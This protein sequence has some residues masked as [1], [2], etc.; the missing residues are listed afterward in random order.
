V[1]QKHD[2]APSVE[3]ET[4]KG[5]SQMKRFVMAAAVVVALVLV[6]S[7]LGAG[8]VPEI[9][10]LSPSFV[11]SS[12]TCENL[13][14]GTTVTAPPGSG[15]GVSV[16]TTLTDRNGVT[17][18][19]NTTH[20]FGSAT[21]Q[22]GNAYVYVYANSFRVSNTTDNL[23]VFSGQMTD[24]FSLSGPGPARL[25]N[26]FTATFTTDFASLVAFSPLESHGDPIDFATG[27]PHCDPL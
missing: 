9:E 17:T 8:G 25:N 2:R 24:H 5:E 13:P 1:R 19:M 15:T 18:I 16:T 6:G 22:D 14:A 3:T 20:E 21:D 11:L 7:A 10:S 4:W 12:A 23:N 26:G 27:A